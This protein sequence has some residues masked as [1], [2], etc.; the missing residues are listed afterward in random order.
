M[1]KFGF[2]LLLLASF[3]KIQ[4]QDEKMNTFINDLM[5]KM[6]VDEKIG[7]LNLTT[8]GGVCHRFSS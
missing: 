1:K 2:L 6:S 3:L 8:A 5:S 4:G 7:Q